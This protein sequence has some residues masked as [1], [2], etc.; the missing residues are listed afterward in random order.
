MA[1]GQFREREPWGCAIRH[2][3]LDSPSVEGVSEEINAGRLDG[4]VWV[5]LDIVG[6]QNGGQ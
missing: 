2:E 3:P 6:G 1:Q 4:A 5:S